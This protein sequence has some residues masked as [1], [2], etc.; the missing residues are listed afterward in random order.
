MRK[1]IF[2]VMVCL[3]L[4]NTAIFAGG[5]RDR[6]FPSRNITMICPWAA[7]GGT[8]AV[9]RA[10]AIAAGRQLGV[11]INVENRTGGG[12]GIGHAAIRNARP[13]G[14]TIGIATFE[15]NPLSAQ[16]LIDF[17]YRDFEPIV[18]LNSES[19]ALTVPIGAPY[20][21]L[22]EFAAFA[23]ANPGRL[24]I[25]NSG[26]GSTQHIAAGL[27]EAAMGIQ[28]THIPFEGG[29]APAL[30]ALVGGHIDGSMMN[31]QEAMSQLHAGNVKTLGV[32]GH[33][34]SALFPDI[35]TF[36]EQG[37]NI[38]KYNWRGIVAPRG[39]DPAIRQTLV[40]AFSAAARDPEFI[41]LMQTLNLS[42]TYL[43]A[44]EFGRFMADNYNMVVTTLRDL[45]MVD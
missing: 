27:M 10:I 20:N 21:S 36:Q 24:N 5:G 16:G 29:S 8:D 11:T 34:R 32:M 19:A 45:G 6:T 22:H 43:P 1:I 23:R 41:S 9:A 4:V 25:S 13:D 12:G 30:T 42:L 7:G 35:P 18:L 37:F 33:N 31:L 44:D 3:M 17:S 40:N 26:P 15:L 39:L 2:A 14:Y 38:T 28:I